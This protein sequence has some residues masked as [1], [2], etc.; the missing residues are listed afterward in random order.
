MTEAPARTTTHVFHRRFSRWTALVCSFFLLISVARAQVTDFGILTWQW[1]CGDPLVTVTFSTNVNAAA[2][3]NIANYSFSPAATINSIAHTPPSAVVQLN[4][5]TLSTAATNTLTVTNIT[6][7]AGVALDPQYSQ[8]FIYCHDH[9]PTILCPDDLIIACVSGSGFTTN[10]VVEVFDADGDPLEV[11]WNIN[12]ADVATNAVPAGNPVTSDTDSL[13]HTYPIG[14]NSVIVSVTDGTYTNTCD[15]RVIVHPAGTP[16]IDCPPGPF[17][18]FGADCAN[19]E[20]FDLS[21]LVTIHGDCYTTNDFTFTHNPP[22]GTPLPHGTNIVTLT[23]DGPNGFQQVCDLEF[24]VD[25]PPDP[26]E[27]LCPDPGVQV[28]IVDCPA[29]MPDVTS[30]V[31]LSGNCDPS[32]YT[33]TQSIPVGTT[34]S[35]GTYWVDVTVTGPGGF[36]ENCR[37]TV[38]VDMAPPRLDCRDQGVFILPVNDDCEAV[39]PPMPYTITPG[40]TP[41]IDLVV[42]QTPPAG[43]LLGPGLHWVTL[44]V[45]DPATGQSIYCRFQVQVVDR[46]PPLVQCPDLEPVPDCEA[47]IPDLTPQLVIDPHCDDIADLDIVQAPPAGTLVGPGTHTIT[48]TVTDTAGNTTQCTTLFEVLGTGFANPIAGLQNTGVDASGTLLPIHAPDPHYAL[49]SSANPTTFPGPDTYV[50]NPRPLSWV[51]NTGVSQWISM[52]SN[53]VSHT[54]GSYVYRIEFMLPA[55]FTSATISGQWASDNNSAILL[56]GTPTGFT[57]PFVGFGFMTPFTINT[58]FVPGLNVLEFDVNVVS[59]FSGLHVTDLEGTVYTC[60]EDPPPCVPPSVTIAP[61]PSQTVAWGGSA[62]FSTTVSGTPTFSYQWYFNGAPI[63]GAN[64]ATLT[65]SPATFAD[66]GNYSVMVSNPCGEILSADVQLRVRRRWG[67][68]IDHWHI[69][70]PAL[71]VNPLDPAPIIGDFGTPLEPLPPG[72]DP[73][74]AYASTAVATRFASTSAFGI[75]GPDGVPVDVMQFTYGLADTGYTLAYDPATLTQQTLIMDLYVP[76]TACLL[77]LLDVDIAGENEVVYLCTDDQP[78]PEPGTRAVQVPVGIWTRVIL[79]RDTG[80][81]IFSGYSLRRDGLVEQFSLNGSV[82]PGTGDYR[83]LP[84]S[85]TDRGTVYLRSLSWYEQSFSPFELAAQGPASAADHTVVDPVMEQAQTSVE[86]GGESGTLR[87]RWR[88]ADFIAQQSTNLVDWES[89]PI[90]PAL[91]TDTAEEVEF[92]IDLPVENQPMQF[93]RAVSSP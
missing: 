8:T 90:P 6:S 37:I 38:G 25:C 54:S 22:I 14:T 16:A 59:L 58:G 88:T 35:N 66:S 44:E 91:I 49:V 12:G 34:L 10:S 45:F 28:N 29:L 42:T 24:I 4:V 41:L 60:E 23:I 70:R 47:E 17:E 30:Y 27:V 1:D 64:G 79:V 65:V 78:A 52:A 67:V 36:E 39:L 21:S 18:I 55:T 81:H 71:P 11:V 89:I 77:P 57:N 53:L 87:L 50:I 69:G 3:T 83:F 7:L 68:L 9:A 26:C 73:V 92:Q 76:E 33:F 61:F 15:F 74:D 80:Q 63:P 43:T 40:C 56:N 62:T 2:A 82:P 51:P 86:P 72:P 93:Y 20:V 5:S 75:P 85:A 19:P 84:S 46:L 13:T 48:V 31:T 32:Q